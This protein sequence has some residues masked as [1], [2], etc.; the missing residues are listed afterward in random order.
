M[1]NKSSVS[2]AGYQAIGEFW[3]T[4]DATFLSIGSF[5]SRFV[6]WQTS[7]GSAKQRC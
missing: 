7:E 3:D 1:A 2:A 5:G 4:H 6:P